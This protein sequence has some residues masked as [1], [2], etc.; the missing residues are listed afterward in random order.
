MNGRA[1][2]CNWSGDIFDNWPIKAVAVLNTHISLWLIFSDV[3][4]INLFHAGQ[5]ILAQP[6]HFIYFISQIDTHSGSGGARGWAC[7]NYPVS[8][9]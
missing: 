9:M 8:N 4:R 5:T 6:C 2:G 1:D 3:D 7:V